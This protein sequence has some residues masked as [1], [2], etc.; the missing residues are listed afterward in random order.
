MRRYLGIDPGV[1]GAV[2]VLAVHDD[3]TQGLTVH[4]TPCDWVQVGTGKRRRYAVD[5]CAELLRGAATVSLAYVEQQSA[6]PKQGVSSSFQTGVGYGIWVALLT[7]LAI[8]YAIVP[9]PRWRARVGLA[10]HPKGTDKKHLKAAVRLAACRR[11]PA[12][13]IN[14][15]HADAVM[16]AVAAALEHGLDD[17]RTA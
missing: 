8:P 1:T 10:A 17:R 15:E 13:P 2:A 9:P 6:R 3:G 12:V 16:M 14:L 4:A 5:R 7:A 11:F